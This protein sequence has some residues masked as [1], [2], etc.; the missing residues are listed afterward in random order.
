MIQPEPD[1]S[2]SEGHAFPEDGSSSVAGFYPT[3]NQAHEHALVVLAMG[4]P[5]SIEHDT[6]SDR[7]LLLV[8]TADSERILREIEAYDRESEEAAREPKQVPIGKLFSHGSGWPHYLVWA[9]TAVLV[10][11]L[12]LRDPSVTERFASTSAAIVEGGEW[13]RPFTS[14]FLHGDVTHLVGNLFGAMFFVTILSRVV[15][16]PWAWLLTLASGTT[17]NAMV[18]MLH[19][20]DGFSSIG[21][22]TAVFGALGLLSGL[23]FAATLHLRFAVQRARAAAPV[24]AGI[25]LLGWMGGGAPGGNTDVLGHVLGFA[26]GLTTGFAI[27][28][29]SDAVKLDRAD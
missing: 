29:C 15:G 11:L 6:V 3:A 21:A 23:G 18:A 24:L 2:A 13:W 12:Q 14:L 10:F 9:A 19:G 8:E 26:S 7:Y 5:C 25:V 27:G 17:G 4:L 1:R 20:A 16:A 22:S 28:L